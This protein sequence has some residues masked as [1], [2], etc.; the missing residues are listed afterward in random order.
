MIR[1]NHA[2]RG[3]LLK[4]PSFLPPV[5]ICCVGTG[6]FLMLASLLVGGILFPSVLENNGGAGSTNRIKLPQNYDHLLQHR[7]RRMITKG[8]VDRNN[9]REAN[10]RVTFPALNLTKRTFEN[11]KRIDDDGIITDG[12][13]PFLGDLYVD[14]F[15]EE[16]QQRAIFHDFRLDRRKDKVEKSEDIESYYMFDDDA[17][18]NPYMEWEDDAI[19]KD[20]RCRR[21]SWHRNLPINC[22]SVHEM[23]YQGNVVNSRLSYLTSGGYRDVY[24]VKL[25]NDV[26]VVFKDFGVAAKFDY[27]DVE[28]NRMDSIVAERLSMF[29]DLIVDIYGFCALSHIGEFMPNGEFEGKAVKNGR[30]EVTL[31]DKDHLDPQNNFK[32]SEKLRYALEMAEAVLLLHSWPDG[33]MVHDDIQ[34]TQFLFTPDGHL[35]LNDFNRAEIML[36]NEE[37]NEYCR[38]RNHPGHGDWRAP[39]EYHDYPLNEKIDTFSL[40]N[41][42]YATLTGVYPYYDVLEMKAVKEKIKKGEKPFIDPRWRERSFAEN[43]LVELIEKCYQY[44]PD[45]RVDIFEMVK[46]LRSAVEENTKNHLHEDE[47]VVKDMIRT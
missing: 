29:K 27:A 18:R 40:G 14:V 43:K 46:F 31:N 20:K 4:C 24:T 2:L 45:D 11:P 44:N 30:H 22:N 7:N 5:K 13:M 10:F 38:Y 32:P 6:V 3:C 41:N 39:E 19:K 35:K 28:F 12:Q 34:M 9:F 33:V 25:E 36:W 21:V 16:N 15:E 37:D 8:L 17:E 42:M 26:S 23:D 1:V 47:L